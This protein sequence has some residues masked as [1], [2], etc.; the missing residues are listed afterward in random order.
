MANINYLNKLKDKCNLNDEFID[1]IKEIFAK[2][3][4]FGYISTYTSNVLAKKL[5]KNID[6]IIFGN[7]KNIDYKSGY[8]D[9]VKKELYIKD[10]KNMPSIYLHLIYILVTNR[11]SNETYSIGYSTTLLSKYDYKISHTNFG[12]N[13]AIISNLVC[14]LLY[15]LPTSLSIMPN[16]RTY[17]NT[18]LGYKIT[19]E[20]DIYFL[21]GK[22][23]S[24]ICSALDIDEEKL[25]YN[26]FTR[27][28]NKY[29]N[30]TL[31]KY[32]LDKNEDL[33]NLLD[34]IS[35]K[36]SNYNKLC[37]FNKLL[38]EN[39]LNIRK[40]SFT[41][42]I[43][44]L[45]NQNKRIKNHINEALEKLNIGLID[46]SSE[47]VSL[48]V[49]GSLSEK[50]N[51]LEEI[52][53]TN[54]LKLQDSLVNII[55][56]NKQKYSPIEFA[57]KLKKLELLQVLKNNIL[58]DELYNT[59][60]NDL[61][62]RVEY[63]N[64]NI[65]EKIKYSLIN[66]ILATNKFD[67]VRKNLTFRK[68]LDLSNSND[69]SYIILNIDNSFIELVKV[70]DLNNDM[71][72]LNNNTRVINLTNL[73]HLLNSDLVNIHTDRIE[74]VFST[75]KQNYENL[76]SILLENM[77]ICTVDNIDLLIIIQNNE[78]YIIKL[79]YSKENIETTLLELSDLY[80]VFGTIS[81][82][83]VPTIYKRR[84]KFLSNVSSII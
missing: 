16:Y 59:I 79:N 82:P 54:I 72:N 5:Y 69:T 61:I 58:I 63:S 6:V 32:R 49:E 19:T 26:I 37:Y 17:E 38:N 25:Y 42:T 36:Y 56:S 71:K 33:F 9:A 75:I 35:R 70:T 62:I 1:I 10:I 52:I 27:N 29:I 50:I 31:N 83:N 12:I 84:G 45:Q 77:Y 7:E 43:E 30:K 4:D 40:Y 66:E 23:L 81:N 11:I 8:Y 3:I 13:R 80:V 24:Q 18:F 46:Y 28:P 47:D 73:K 68:V 44:T 15:T 51:F 64:I 21:E 55:I 74:Q 22:L 67:R 34:E 39:Y 20:N 57:S 78:T 76:K 48:S 65:V 41:D 60:S 2:L 14:R 53:V